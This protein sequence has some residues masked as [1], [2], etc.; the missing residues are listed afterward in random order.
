LKRAADVTVIITNLTGQT[1]KKLDLG[2]MN[3]GNNQI[4]IDISGLAPGI[5]FYS[6]QADDQKVTSKMV[7]GE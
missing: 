2:M 3:S 4:M 1:I 5:Y 7:V 6:V